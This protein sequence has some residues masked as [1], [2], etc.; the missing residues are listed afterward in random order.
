MHIGIKLIAEQYGYT[1]SYLDCAHRITRRE[2]VLRAIKETNPRMVGFSIDT[3]NIFSAG[4]MSRAIKKE[5]GPDIKVNF[6]GPA[7]R[8]GPASIVSAPM[9]SRLFAAS[10]RTSPSFRRTTD[11][12]GLSATLAT[13]EESTWSTSPWLCSYSEPS[14][15]FTT[16]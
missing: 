15:A 4:R 8:G 12:C 16:R 3:D 5:L 7:S 11:L 2:E 14:L 9:A 10:T 1:A 6:G 13:K